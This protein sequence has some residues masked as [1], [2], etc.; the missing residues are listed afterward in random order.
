MT[1]KELDRWWELQNQYANT[2][3][4]VD[5]WTHMEL[6]RLNHDVMALANNVH[7]DNMIGGE[8]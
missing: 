2:P 6:V 4:E 1:K 5:N 8:K 7:N 3:E